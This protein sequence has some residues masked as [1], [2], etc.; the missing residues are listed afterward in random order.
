MLEAPKFRE[1]NDGKMH[2]YF[3]DVGQGDSAL[4]K[5]PSK[6]LILI[7]G[8]PSRGVVEKISD[9]LPFNISKIDLVVVSHSH[10]DHITG[11]IDILENYEVGCVVYDTEDPSISETES[12]LRDQIELRGIKLISTASSTSIPSEC[13]SDSDVNLNI[14]SLRNAGALAN[15]D[16]NDNQNLESNIVILD[17]K[18]FESLFLGDAEIPVQIEL[19][20]FLNVDIE[21]M[22]SG[23][24]GSVDSFYI[25][26]IEK[27][28]PDLAILSVGKNNSYGHPDKELLEEYGRMNLEY[29]RTDQ[30]GTIEVETDGEMWDVITENRVK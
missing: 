10:A 23:H 12:H 22:K 1:Y 29:A 25:D 16:I 8:G 30:D 24:H 11:L 13:F 4:I 26:L 18:D 6:K 3:F 15:A 21:V 5:L 17:Y 2:L 14:Y 9:K 28:S 20:E 27:L 7:D 19:L